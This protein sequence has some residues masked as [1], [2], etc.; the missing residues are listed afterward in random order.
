[1]PLAKK[2]N[3][4]ASLGRN[5][6]ELRRM[7]YLGWV[8][9][10]NPPQFH[11]MQRFRILIALWLSSSLLLFTGCETLLAV[12]EEASKSGG[13]VNPT[14]GEMAAGL[15]EALK[16]GTG[17]A[18]SVLSQEGGY[19]DNPRVRIPFPPDA[20]FAADKLRDLGL[21]DLV[22][23]FVARLNEGAEE[24][25]KEAA[26]IFRNAITQMTITDA[27]DILVTRDRDAATDYF[28]RTTSD[29][30]YAAFSPKIRRV[31]NQVNATQLWTDVTS[32]YNKIPFTN[33]K[34][35][36]DLVRYATDKALEGLFLKVAEEEA[37]IRDN[38]SARSSDLLR[39]VFG[40]AERELA[41]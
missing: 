20:Q 3:R 16:K 9:D 30:L 34:I 5:L 39:E 26:P 4:S 1:M 33:R 11:L 40:Y 25:A 22:D 35:E 29:E 18:V 27:R 19:L 41:R 6:V 15:K 14:T 10:A 12:A 7:C 37:K 17:Q 32:A 23:D 28:R 13:V 24:G 21:G 36:T 2:T 31:L 38:V 8:I